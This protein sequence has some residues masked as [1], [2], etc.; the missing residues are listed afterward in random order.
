[1]QFIGMY[2]ILFKLGKLG[3]AL[4]LKLLLLQEQTFPATEFEGRNG[5]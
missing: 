4:K 5:R 2:F 3:L 1:M